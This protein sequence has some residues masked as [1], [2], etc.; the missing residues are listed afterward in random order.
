MSLAV[1][2][3]VEA[4]GDQIAPGENL[5]VEGVP[6]IPASLTETVGRYTENRS[7]F[8]TDWH[9]KRR[10]MVIG[11]RFGNT[12][13]AHIVKMPGGARQQLTFF[14]EPVYGASFQPKDG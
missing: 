8:Q 11:T 13:Q 1:G 4:Q 5:V 2:F 7:A 3:S 10:E 6:K 9:P 14:A 12:Y